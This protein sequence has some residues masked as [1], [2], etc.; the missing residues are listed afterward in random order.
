MADI[1]TLTMNPS[2]DQSCSTP[3]ITNNTKLRCTPPKYDPG[4]G[5]INVARAITNLGGT[6]TAI[7]PVGGC[8]GTLL[9]QL[10]NEHHLQHQGIPIAGTTRIDFSVVD[11][12]TGKQ[13]RFNMPGAPMTTDEWH[14][15]IHALTDR[16]T[17]T[18]LVLSGSLPP[19][20]PAEFY[21][22]VID[23]FKDTDCRIIL[24]TSGTPLQLATQKHIFFLKPNLRELGELTGH[25]IDDEDTLITQAKQLIDKG[26]CDALAVSLGA[27]GAYFF[28]KDCSEHIIAPLVP[29]H[30]RIGAGDSM[31]AGL[32]LALSRGHPLPSAIRYGVAA[33]TAAVLRPGTELCRLDDTERLYHRITQ[34]EA[35]TTAC[36]KK[37]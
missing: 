30:S 13:Y 16:P 19:G 34:T 12:M 8:E 6:A 3:F 21:S 22:H 36:S 4:G 24:D 31:V 23:A 10:L 2:V 18:Y 7:Y 5:G 28:S 9:I 37:P 17:P 35:N 15:C 32:T 1:L 29:I 20:V 33:G 26:T 25:P 11:D 27:A 14:A